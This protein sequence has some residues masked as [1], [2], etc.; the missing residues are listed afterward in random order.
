MAPGMI[1]Q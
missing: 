1:I